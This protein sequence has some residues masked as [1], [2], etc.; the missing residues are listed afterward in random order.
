MSEIITPTD[1]EHTITSNY[2]QLQAAR[3]HDE[4]DLVKLFEHRMNRA[5]DEYGDFMRFA[6]AAAMDT[7]EFPAIESE[8]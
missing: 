8:S 4:K 3:D 1:L 7:I 5:L 6:G 2:A